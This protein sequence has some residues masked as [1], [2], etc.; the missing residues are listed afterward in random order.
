[1]EEVILNHLKIIASTPPQYQR[2]FLELLYTNYLFKFNKEIENIW[3]SLANPKVKAMA[4]EHLKASN[5]LPSTPNYTV[6]SAQLYFYQK[7]K[8]II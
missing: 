2:A 3:Q 7:E 6:D 5:I 8:T 1:M 4:L